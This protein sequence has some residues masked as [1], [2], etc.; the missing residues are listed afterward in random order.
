[1]GVDQLDPVEDLRRRERQQALV[2]ELGRS[3]LTGTEL[4]ELFAEALAAAAEGLSGARVELCD[5]TPDTGEPLV[6]ERELAVPIRGPEQPI[7]VLAAHSTDV[8]FGPDDGLFLRALANL[9]GIAAARESADERRRE[10][11]ASLGLLAEAGHTLATT[12]DYQETLAA[13]A[14]LVVP[15]LADWFIVDVAGDDG[16]LR[17]V[18][19]TAADPAKQE[20]L[21]ELAVKYPPRP[22][23]RQ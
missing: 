4:A 16:R 12:R 11:E 3:A 18:A 1:M 17:R 7:S 10:S 21:D 14:K 8:P 5:P 2:A 20:L 6:T 22:G 19:V 9:L 13:L 23:S 15:G